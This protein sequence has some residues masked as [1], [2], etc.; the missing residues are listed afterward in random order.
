MKKTWRNGDTVIRIS[1]I[2]AVSIDANAP[3]TV[4]IY[5]RGIA[6]IFSFECSSVKV[7]I[8]LVDELQ[9]LIEETPE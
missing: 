1:D 4:L 5:V 9:Q 2:V 7:A 8:G 6:T 3:K